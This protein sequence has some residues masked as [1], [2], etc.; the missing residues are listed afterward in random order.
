M[1]ITATEILRQIIRASDEAPGF[2]AR[3]Q[4]DNEGEWYQSA[5]FAAWINEGRKLLVS[6]PAAPTDTAL[7]EAVEPVLHWY[8]SD[9]HDNRPLIDIVRDIV[10]DLQSDRKDA[11]RAATLC[12]ALKPF[13]R[14]AEW[15]KAFSDQ[16]RITSLHQ[17]GDCL[18][19]G[20]LRAAAAALN[21]DP[22]KGGEAQEID[23]SDPAV[24]IIYAAGKEIGSCEAAD[25]VARLRK[26]LKLYA[27][28]VEC[29]LCE[30][31]VC[32]GHAARA[33]LAGDA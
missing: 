15:W 8:Q 2:G 22:G 5:D 7:R 3:D 14:A 9:E 13:A 25:E 31:P 30:R 29:D 33:A 20:H 24:E 6:T 28:D 10:A 19:V 1:K 32:S 11:L 23:T 16:Q 26:A 18:E 27:D 17:H 21:P 12:E 4:C